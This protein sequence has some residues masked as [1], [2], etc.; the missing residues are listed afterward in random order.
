MY[1][2]PSFPKCMRILHKKKNKTKQ[3]I[4]KT[5]EAWYQVPRVTETSICIHRKSVHMTLS[6]SIFLGP[7]FSRTPGLSY[8]FQDTWVVP[9]CPFLL[10]INVCRLISLFKRCSQELRSQHEVSQPLFLNTLA[11]NI[12]KMNDPPPSCPTPRTFEKWIVMFSE[13][14]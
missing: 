1:S 14:W 12:S 5:Q 3:T 7:T 6:C 8:S 4:T 9:N 11:N 13:K 10:K 2:S